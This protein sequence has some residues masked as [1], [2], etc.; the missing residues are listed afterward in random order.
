[1]EDENREFLFNYS[2]RG[3]AYKFLQTVSFDNAS[4]NEQKDQLLQDIRAIRQKSAEWSDFDQAEMDRL[5]QIFE[6]ELEQASLAETENADAINRQSSQMRAQVRQLVAL[7]NGLLSEAG[8]IES[9]IRWVTEV[10]QVLVSLDNVASESG[11]FLSVLSQVER[12]VTDGQVV[13]LIDGYRQKLADYLYLDELIE[14]NRNAKVDVRLDDAAVQ[15][16]VWALEAEQRR[17]RA[18][19]VDDKWE[20]QQN[21]RK[22]SEAVKHEILGHAKYRKFVAA[23][24]QVKSLKRQIEELNRQDA[25]FKKATID[26]MHQ[27]Q[28]LELVEWR[29][30]PAKVI[31]M[32]RDL[33]SIDRLRK[34]NSSGFRK[35]DYH[36][37]TLRTDLRSFFTDNETRLSELDQLHA[38]LA[39]KRETLRE[40]HGKEKALDVILGRV[41]AE[42]QTGKGGSS[43]GEDCL[44]DLEVS[45]YFYYMSL[46]QMV[47]SKKIVYTEFMKGFPEAYQRRLIGRLMADLLG[48]PYRDPQMID[49][50]SG[51]LTEDAL[52]RSK[53]SYVMMVNKEIDLVFRKQLS[54]DDMSES[55]FYSI[56]SFVGFSKEVLRHFV[57]NGIIKQLMHSLSQAIMSFLSLV[58]IPFLLSLFLNGLLSLI[59]DLFYSWV[60]PQMENFAEMAREFNQGL[61]D[62]YVTF[63]EAPVDSLDVDAALAEASETEYQRVASEEAKEEPKE[64]T[65][66]VEYYSAKLEEIMSIKN[67]FI[68]VRF[69]SSKPKSDD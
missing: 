51:L 69:V 15:T 35:E 23:V 32:D 41:L 1:M 19:L 14:S 43:A 4:I 39:A 53:N 13:A 7:K 27:L 40:L 10:A 45:V 65:D 2:L 6:S 50:Q 21:I 28:T 62:I 22:K 63:I 9:R 17:I 56:L 37:E 44:Y 60:E 33:T 55:W 26:K 5:Q 49:P 67:E 18:A 61:I 31:R 48:R 66:R 64:Q 36:D 3:F 52:E 34:I 8:D 29:I 47:V 42:L 59:Y 46:F 30:H 24:G 38:Q 16:S 11:S 25:D 58:Y 20:L 12:L 57:K 54:G 68:T